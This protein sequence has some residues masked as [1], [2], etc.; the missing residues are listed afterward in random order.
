M[1]RQSPN[2]LGA[3]HGGR[4]CHG[5]LGGPDLEGLLEGA[6][7]LVLVAAVAVQVR[8]GVEGGGAQ[9]RAQELDGGALA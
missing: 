6:E 7:R 8:A 9:A 2:G 4:P 3:W 5:L 1:G